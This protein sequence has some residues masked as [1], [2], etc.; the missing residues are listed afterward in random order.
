MRVW[1]RRVVVLPAAV[2]AGTALV[3]LVLIHTPWA[4]HRALAWATDFVT[5][6]DLTLRATDLG[7]NAF[8]RRITLTDVRL[9]A[10]GHDDRPFLVAS[11]LDVQLPWMALRG[12]FAIDHLA[13]E[14]GV[15]DIHRDANGVVNLPPGSSQPHPTRTRPAVR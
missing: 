3:A 11:R 13:I 15:V 8:T 7:Y 12:P 6:F 14:G 9:A 5:R 10:K 1:L 4:R 2:A